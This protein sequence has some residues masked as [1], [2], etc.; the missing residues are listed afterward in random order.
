MRLLYW[1]KDGYFLFGFWA[2]PTKETADRNKNSRIRDGRWLL[3]DFLFGPG[4]QIQ[5]L[6]HDVFP[7]KSG[8]GKD[9]CSHHNSKQT[10]QVCR[11]DCR[12]KDCGR[13]HFERVGKNTR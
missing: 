9:W 6:A 7:Q 12:N 1:I 13:V 3:A 11:D 5:H 10:K 4:I 2:E 8:G